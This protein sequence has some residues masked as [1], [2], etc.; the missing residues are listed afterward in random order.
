MMRKG[1]ATVFIII[2]ILLIVL[3][4]LSFAFKD[5]L[6]E[7]VSKVEIAKGL[8]MSREARKVQSDLEGCLKEVSELGL[9]V[10][11]LQGGY[12][13]LDSRI[14]H[15][16]TSTTVDYIPYSGTAYAYFKG[17]NLVPTK[18][19]MEK[20][21]SDFVTT[22]SGIC[23]K[24]YTGLEVDYGRI[25][26]STE[27]KDDKIKL[28]FDLDVKAKKEERE[29]GFKNVKIEIP[30][31]LGTIQNV[32]DEI[33]DQQIKISE[34]E[35]CISCITRIAAEN[36]M[37]V[38]IDRVGNDIFYAVTDEKSEIAGGA[39]MFLLANKF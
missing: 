16:D 9:V 3:I 37:E 4:A 35:L 27:I 11:G 7:Q 29:S 5:S 32:V 38:D 19:M 18:E 17:Q 23:E 25:K 30:I 34:E 36:G 12:T 14:Q 2:G 31:R 20:Q 13:T 28:N 6:M 33:I 15:T 39:Y 22:G 21:L 24:Q 10:M 8:T 1:Q 26:V